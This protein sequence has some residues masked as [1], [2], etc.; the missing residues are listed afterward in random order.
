MRNYIIRAYKDIFEIKWLLKNPGHV[1][2]SVHGRRFKVPGDPES[3]LEK[4]S[5]DPYEIT[6]NKPPLAYL[7]CP[8]LVEK[9]IQERMKDNYEINAKKNRM[10]VEEYAK[11]L[12]TKAKELMKD[13]IPFVAIRTSTLSKI[14]EDGKFKSQFESGTST[15]LFAPSIRA[16][17][18]NELFGYSINRT[19]P[20]KRPIY[21]YFSNKPE[22]ETSPLVKGY[23][24]VVVR[25]KPDIMKRTTV[26]MTD[27][28][29]VSGKIAP[30]PVHEADRTIFDNSTMNGKEPLKYQT[31]EDVTPYPEAQYHGGVSTN[32]IEHVLLPKNKSTPKD[33]ITQLEKMNISYSYELEG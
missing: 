25:F 28:L 11:N 29:G 10:T 23:G 7:A 14:L 26:T 12:D 31:L 4:P 17:G 20:E 8:E 15:A 32:D 3:G 1:D 9:N 22:N 30:K 16:E 6:K 27:S 13:A 19:P 21:G 33:I 5:Y 24:E 18:E 2:Q